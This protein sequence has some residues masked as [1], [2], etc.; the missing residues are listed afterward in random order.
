MLITPS[1]EQVAF[2]KSAI[3]TLKEGSFFKVKIEDLS[4]PN[5]GKYI[6][7]PINTTGDLSV[8]LKSYGIGLHE[9]SYLVNDIFWGSRADKQ[10]LVI[11]S[12]ITE[13]HVP[14]K[15]YNPYYIYIPCFIILGGIYLFQRKKFLCQTTSHY[16][17]KDLSIV[18]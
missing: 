6:F 7:I 13:L 10:N 12:Q 2:Q 16:E 1:Y 11:G 5:S 15:G 8:H 4:Q 3:P 18:K 9:D 14:V 17:E